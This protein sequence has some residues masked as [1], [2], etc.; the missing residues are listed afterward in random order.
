MVFGKDSDSNKLATDTNIEPD[1]LNKINNEL[2]N[3]EKINKVIYINNDIFLNYMT[4]KMSIKRFLFE[5]DVLLNKY[6]RTD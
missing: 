5:K 3:Y 4:P 2:D 1:I 6:D